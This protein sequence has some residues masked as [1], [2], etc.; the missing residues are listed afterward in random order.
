[1]RRIRRRSLQLAA[2]ATLLLVP[3]LWAFDGTGPSEIVEAEVVRTKRYKHVTQS[4]SHDHVRA[5]LLIDGRSEHVLEK[6]DSYTRGQ[7]VRVWIRRG[8][9]SGYPYFDD[10]VKPGEI[11]SVVE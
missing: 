11:E 7:R 8:R 9:F 4:G 10:L 6:A 2:V 3:S 5:T 1:M